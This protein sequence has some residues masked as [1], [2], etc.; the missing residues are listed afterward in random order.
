MCSRS[1]ESVD[2]TAASYGKDGLGFE[3]QLAQNICFFLQ[4]H[5]D[6]L[7]SPKT[8]LMNGYRN[9]FPEVKQPVHEFYHL[10]P[11]SAEISL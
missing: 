4:N 7:W 10:P 2:G 6:R 8:L 1:W 5:P 9:S 3:S 11:S